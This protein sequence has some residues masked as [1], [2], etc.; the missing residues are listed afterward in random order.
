MTGEHPFF[1]KGKGWVQVNDL[2]PGDTFRNMKGEFTQVFVE[3]TLETKSVPVYNFEV[4]GAHTYFVG[5]TINDAIL[6]HNECPYCNSPSC[7]GTNSAWLGWS[8]LRALYAGHGSACDNLYY[9]AT[10]AAGVSYN[11]NKEYAH[12]AF[13]IIS[14]AEPTGLADATGAVK[15]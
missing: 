8:P 11:A 3:K 13:E 2:E 5:E 4:E 6:V 7:T 10:A 9:G 1:E 12:T 15:F 14:V